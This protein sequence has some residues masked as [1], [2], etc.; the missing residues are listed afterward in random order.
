MYN[1]NRHNTQYAIRNTHL[2]TPKVWMANTTYSMSFTTATLLYHES[3]TVAGLYAELGDWDAVREKVIAQNLLQMRTLNSSRR[4]YQ[5]VTSRL[6]LLTPGQM[7]LLRQGSRQEQNYLLWLAIC[8]RYRFIYDFAAEVV[9][10]KYLRLDLD[11]AAGDYDAFFNA[12]AEWHPEVERVATSTRVKQ[13]Q[14]L[15]K[16]M[17]EAELLAGDHQIVPAVLTPSLI[18]AIE[19]D[20]PAHF[21]IFPVRGWVHGIDTRI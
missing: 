17:R 4:I 6:K 12:K 14:F 8:K 7:A 1:A 2:I 16:I 11:L 15:F 10:E 21:A 9:R 5:E 19:T 20:D 18:E 13:R 3:L